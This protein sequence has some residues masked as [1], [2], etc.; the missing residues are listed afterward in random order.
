M[1]KALLKIIDFFYP[2]F[3][4]WLPLHTFRY[5]FSGGT[6]AGS[7]IV[8]YYIVYNW[9]LQQKDIYLDVPVLPKMI[10]APVAA[11]AIESVLTF[12]IGFMLNKYL[13]FT[14]SDLKGRIQLFR[15][16]SIVAT[17][18]LLNLALLKLLV[19]GFGFY[20]TPSKMLITLLLAVFSYFSQKHFSFKVKK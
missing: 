14:Q 12:I 16:A 7:S 8:I 6:T 1:R 15:Y 9:V 3:S 18:V 10:T 13:V 2:P 17:N 19:E 4:K 11:L 20:A 5:L